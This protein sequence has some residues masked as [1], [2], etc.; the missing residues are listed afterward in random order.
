MHCV[1]GWDRTP[2]FISLIRC[3]L[4]ADGLAHD[5]LAPPEMLYLTLAYDW[6]LFGHPL[7]IRRQA[8]EEIL[9]FTFHLLAHIAG[10]PDLSL[11]HVYVDCLFILIYRITTLN[12][13]EGSEIC[14]NEDEVFA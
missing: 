14:D 2:L 3:L 12:F 7:T 1:S 11:R 4:W 9:R 13:R 5:S 8:G 6:F 10:R